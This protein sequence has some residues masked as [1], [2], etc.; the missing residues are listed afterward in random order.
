MRRFQPFLAVCLITCISISALGGIDPPVRAITNPSQA[1]ML[2]HKAEIPLEQQPFFEELE[3]RRQIWIDNPIGEVIGNTPQDT[4]LNFYAVMAIVGTESNRITRSANG[5]PGLRW[6]RSTH[7]E[8]EEIEHLFEVAVKALDSSEFPESIRL[9][10]A[11]ESAIE[12][13]HLLD[14]IF[15]HSEEKL[16]LIDTQS[17]NSTNLKSLDKTYVWRMPGTPISLTNKLAG[18]TTGIGYYFTIDTVKNA[19]AIYNEITER[20]KSMIASEYITPTFYNDF[21]HTPGHLVPPKWYAGMP[22]WAH[23]FFQQ[24]VLGKETLFQTSAGLIAIAIYIVIAFVCF[25]FIARQL[26]GGKANQTITQLQVITRARVLGALIPFI[27]LTKFTENFVDGFLNLTGSPLVITTY[28]FEILYFTN[29]S[30]AC[31]FFL[32]VV[33]RLTQRY[34]SNRHVTSA[35]QN[36]IR[37]RQLGMI[38]PA[39]RTT[40]A[41][42]AVLLMYR[43]LLLLGLSSGAVLALSAVPGLA[44]GLGASKLLGNLFAGFSIQIDQHLRIGEFCQVGNITGFVKKIGLRSIQIQTLDSTVTVPNASADESVIINYNAICQHQEGQGLSLTIPIDQPFSTWQIKRLLELV[45]DHIYALHGIG[46]STASIDHKGGQIQ[47]IVYCL[48]N[49]EDLDTWK[50]YLEHRERLLM[51]LE[52]MIAQIRHSSKI[53]RVAFNTSHD[54]LQRIPELVCEAVNSDPLLKFEKCEFLAISEFSYDFTLKFMGHHS[55]YSSFLKSVDKMNQRMV[56]I[57]A[58]NQIEIPFPTTRQ[59]NS[60]LN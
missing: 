39:C 1:S 21:I 53:I 50:E 3:K 30:L 28:G 26:S 6:S 16:N 11:N 35:S 36:M 31:F 8:I 55:D 44:I 14:Y 40:A 15:T 54:K 29:L 38:M 60:S 59:I 37:R 33:G 19:A 34:L 17:T 22:E 49:M 4:L 56:Q 58:N 46:R 57:L 24:E 42:I 47:L 52:Q 41:I 43:L 23:T 48:L 7:Q 12:I 9:H 10:F 45:R 51:K 27:V 5:E 2:Q 18:E 32:E 25:R 13:K 20:L